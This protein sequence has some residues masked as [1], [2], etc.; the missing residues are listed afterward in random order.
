MHLSATCLKKFVF[1]HKCL[2]L[3]LRGKNYPFYVEGF[4]NKHKS[5]SKRIVKTRLT[6]LNAKNIFG[7]SDR[8]FN[9]Q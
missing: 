7:Y 9:T 1:Q 6:L 5:K 8:S 4:E 3:D 2:H